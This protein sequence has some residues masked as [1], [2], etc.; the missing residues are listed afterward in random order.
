[1]RV[2]VRVSVCEYND[3]D[4]YFKINRVDWSLERA[5]LF[6]Y[7]RSSPVHCLRNFQLQTT[8]IWFLRRM[9]RIKWTDKTDKILNEEILQRAETPRSLL[10]VITSKQIRFLG[11]VMRKNQLEAEEHEEDIFFILDWLATACGDQ[12]TSNELLKMCQQ[13]EDIVLIAKVSF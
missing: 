5:V 2:C 6:C 1:M 11:R 13:R 10:K 7:I 4:V 12:C 8:E 3:N 9:L